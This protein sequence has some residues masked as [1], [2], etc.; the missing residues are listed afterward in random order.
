MR[1]WTHMFVG[2]V[3]VMLCLFPMEQGEGVDLMTPKSCRHRIPREEIVYP[4][5]VYLAKSGYALEV[6]ALAEVYIHRRQ[7]GLPEAEVESD[8][9]SKK[10]RAFLRSIYPEVIPYP[11]YWGYFVLHEDNTAQ[12]FQKADW[13][14]E[15]DGDPLL[16]GARISNPP[17][18][19][20]IWLSERYDLCF[21]GRKRNTSFFESTRWL[22]VSF[23]VT[24]GLPPQDDYMPL[25]H[26]P[27]AVHVD[28]L[29]DSNLDGPNLEWL[30]EIPGMK[31]G[32]TVEFYP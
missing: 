13:P 31:L 19:P 20:W 22:L 23:R 29:L 14:I 26:N 25:F 15:Q 10:E 11:L 12:F 17:D 5:V 27:G 32:N 9:Y 2:F 28:A 18:N 21:S 1:R 16:S 30:Y 7:Q 6:A 3:A 4:V 24:F 8:Q